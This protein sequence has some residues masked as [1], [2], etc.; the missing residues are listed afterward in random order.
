MSEVGE[1][2]TSHYSYEEV[3]L[4]HRVAERG[5]DQSWPW[6]TTTDHDDWSTAE[7][8]HKDAADWAWRRRRNRGIRGWH[9][10]LGL[11][12]GF[13]L[14]LQAPDLIVFIMNYSLINLWKC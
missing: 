2:L 12:L 14:G 13:G 4:L 8:V 9:V 3:E 5:C 7:F 11:G 6:Q 1:I 10:E